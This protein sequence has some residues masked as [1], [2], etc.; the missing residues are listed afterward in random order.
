MY[1]ENVMDAQ[2]CCFANLNLF[3]FCLSRCRRRPRC[4]SSLLD[5]EG[6][7]ESVRIKRVEFRENVRTY[8]HQGQGIRSVIK[9]CPSVLS[10]CP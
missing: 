9:R 1:K 10:G 8:F 5:T 4:L 7:K 6:A 3:L 2:S